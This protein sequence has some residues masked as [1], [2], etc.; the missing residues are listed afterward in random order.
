M[1]THSQTVTRQFEPLA[2]QYL[3]SPVHA[4]GPDLDWVDDWLGRGAQPAS[5]LDVGSGPGHLAFR[6]A[7]RCARVCAVDPSAAMLATARTEA[8]RRGLHLDTC[9]AGAGSL[10]LPDGRFD[11][12]ATRFSA[13]HWHDVP[14][15]L[16][17]LHRV[18]R[19]CGQL[20][21]VDLLG[22]DSPLV[23]THLQ[24][25]ELIRDPGHARDLTTAQWQV[26]L[27]GAGWRVS[28][29]RCWP[30]RL[31]FDA[32]TARMRVPATRA[33]LLRELLAEAPSEVRR[34]LAVEA[35]G[36]FT[37]R[38]GLFVATRD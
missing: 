6:L 33:A 24:A 3:D 31:D 10:P 11:L 20:L 38:V 12:V 13:H 18:A 28:Q 21:L 23:D 14:R 30:L 37:A 19:P 29:F 35:D 25:I 2:R 17:E 4:G 5:A 7:A 8:A 36:S 15:S 27:Q 16:M 26:A 9:E 32:W 1:P 34:A 22:D